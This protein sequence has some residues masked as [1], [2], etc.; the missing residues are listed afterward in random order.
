MSACS[1]DE[2]FYYP[3]P[4]AICTLADDALAERLRARDELQDLLIAPLRTENIGIE[5]IIQFCVERPTLRALILC[6]EDARQCVGHL[7]GASF[8]ALRDHG[9]D[10]AGRIRNAPGKRPVLK[11]LSAPAIAHFRNAVTVIDRVDC[12]DDAL[13]VED[14]LKCLKTSYPPCEPFDA[15]SDADAAPLSIDLDDAE[16]ALPWR[17]DPAGYFVIEQTGDRIQMRHYDPAGR[18]TLILRAKTA[19]RLYLEAVARQLLSRMD[20]A[21]YLG[22]ELA[23]AQNSLNTGTTYLQDEDVTQIMTLS[24]S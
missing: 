7:P 2:P 10:D 18:Q 22:R 20:H 19:R 12:A 14:V 6:G 23:R 15:T 17:C 11:N 24:G 3:H 1:S 21:A 8:V 4:V 16:D 13:I 9:V 5:Q